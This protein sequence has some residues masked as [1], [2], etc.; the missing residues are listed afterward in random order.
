MDLIKANIKT[1][2]DWMHC[3]VGNEGTGKSTLG[4]EICQYIDPTFN[5]E[6]I[7]FTPEEL[8][9]AVQKADKYQAIMM[10]EGIESLFVRK[11]M[12]SATINL[13]QMFAQIRYK[14][15]FF[16]V[17]I[18]DWFLLESYTRGHRV[19]SLCRIVNRTQKKGTYSF[20]G[21]RR[22][23]LIKKDDMKKV[24]EYPE[25]AFIES[26]YPLKNKLWDAYTN[27]REAYHKTNRNA[28][29]WKEKLENVKIMK[30]SFTIADLVT[31]F[32]VSKTTVRDWVY[33]KQLVPKRQTFLDIFGQRRITD[34]GY[35]LLKRNIDKYHKV[36][37]FGNPLHKKKGKR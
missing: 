36:S 25:P 15:L 12:A 21:K 7:T 10:D 19:K 17:N 4:I 2:R 9:M 13:V 26:F 5:V 22:I 1:D 31:I 18:P 6:R 20:F 3:N 28:R 33:I 32:G 23:R 37:R 8:Q 34:K 24:T 30:K 14:N 29:V 35:R 16:C 27:K 11:T